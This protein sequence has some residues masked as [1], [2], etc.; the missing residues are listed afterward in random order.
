MTKE[1]NLWQKCDKQKI[2]QKNWEEF[3]WKAIK[4]WHIN[5]GWDVLGQPFAIL[6]CSCD[7]VTYR[8]NWPRGRFAHAYVLYRLHL[9]ILLSL[10]MS[11]RLSTAIKKLLWTMS[12]YLTTNCYYVLFSHQHLVQNTESWKW[13]VYR[14]FVGIPTTVAALSPQR[15]RL[16]PRPLWRCRRCY[17]YKHPLARGRL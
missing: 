4:T 8:L 3:F 1:K 9:Y 17:F 5:N 15:P 16:L 6:Q 7:I 12:W 11:L 2:W 14:P 13:S 10:T